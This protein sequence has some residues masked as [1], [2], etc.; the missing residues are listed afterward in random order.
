[1]AAPFVAGVMALAIPQMPPPRSGKAHAV[2]KNTSVDAGDPGHDHLYGWGLI[3][4]ST[5]LEHSHK[6][7]V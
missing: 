5:A 1:M 7:I 6:A 4:P 2:I 3:N